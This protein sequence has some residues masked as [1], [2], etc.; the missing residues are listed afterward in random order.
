MSSE[1]MLKT[2]FSPLVLSAALSFAAI[3]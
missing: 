1:E 2:A 3:V